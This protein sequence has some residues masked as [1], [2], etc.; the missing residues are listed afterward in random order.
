MCG[1]REPGHTHPLLRVHSL[2][3]D[4]HIHDLVTLQKPNLEQVQVLGFVR[5]VRSKRN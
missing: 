3:D 1:R 2:V 4:E 5:N